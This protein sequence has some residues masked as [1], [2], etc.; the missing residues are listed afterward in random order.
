MA[1]ELFPVFD[2]PEEDEEDGE[3]DTS[4]K[5]SVRWDPALGDFARD[6]SNRMVQC[7]GQEAYMVWCYKTVQ[8]ERDS[9]LAYMEAVSGADLG[10]E[11]EGIMQ[12][13]DRGTVESMVERTITEALEVNP[14]TESVG[15]FVFSWDGDTVHARFEVKGAGWDDTVQICI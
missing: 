7:S 3:Y 15:N 10:V 12:E 1:E 5:R 2:V 6:G 9:C 13:S 11:L 14:R 8:T 4:Y